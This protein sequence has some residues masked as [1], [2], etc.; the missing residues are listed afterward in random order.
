MKI[1]RGNFRRIKYLEN[2]E[3]VYVIQADQQMKMYQMLTHSLNKTIQSLVKSKFEL[4][5]RCLSHLF[6]ISNNCTVSLVA[7]AL[8]KNMFKKLVLIHQGT[9]NYDSM[10]YGMP[11]Y[12]NGM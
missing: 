2:N 7:I 1:I 5:F 6:S 12:F 11:H 10:N 4:A 3:R 8:L 9:L